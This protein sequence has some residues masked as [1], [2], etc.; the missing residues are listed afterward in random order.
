MPKVLI[1][2][3]PLAKLQ[4]DFL[5]VLAGAGFEFVYPNTSVQM[6]E[7]DLMGT[8]QGVSASLAGSEPYTRKVFEAFPQLKVV[9][10]VGVGYDAVDVQ[11][12]TENGVVVGTAPGT[13][14]DSVSEH[15]FMLL[16]A[17]TRNLIRQHNPI[18]DG[19]W[20]RAANLPVRGRTLGLVGLGRIG[21]SMTKR[22][23]AFG[24]K[25]IAYEPFP[26]H[27]FVETHGVKL[28]SLDDLLREADFVSLHLPAMEGTFKLINAARLKLMK[29]TAFLINTAR[30][31]V[32][33]E[34]ALY[35]ALRDKKIAGAG[36]D[37]FE[38]EPPRPD[39]PILKLDNVVMTAHTA[40]VDTQSRD[41]MARKAA[42]C[43]AAISRGEWPAE[44][45][46]NPE[47]KAKFKW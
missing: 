30:G 33:D 16:L 23:L 22:A 7:A 6:T 10:R 37:V 34:P 27:T 2:P 11:A 8:L 47:V 42:E 1:A 19:N 43:I 3:A 24:M 28:L 38:E 20:P 26:D 12:A 44:C 36:L 17:L 31:A 14:Q 39:N 45:V 25:V 9:A 15:C 21:K 5:T 4:G 40:G 41:D 18:R 32:V 35:E 13:N 29:P 46:V